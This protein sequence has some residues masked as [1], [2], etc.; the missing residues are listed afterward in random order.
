MTNHKSKLE[1]HAALAVMKENTIT[2]TTIPDGTCFRTTQLLVLLVACPPGPSPLT[3][4]SF[5][6]ASVSGTSCK[7][8]LFPAA[9]GEGPRLRDSRCVLHRAALRAAR[10]NAKANEFG[11][12]IQKGAS[13][14][15]KLKHRWGNQRGSLHLQVSVSA[16]WH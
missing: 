13:L 11:T 16:W 6:S 7:E 5:S 14:R 4:C 9:H 8:L 3:N 12:L 15:W 10:T 2:F 1:H